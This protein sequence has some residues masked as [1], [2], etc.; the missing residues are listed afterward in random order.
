MWTGNSQFS[1]KWPKC[2]QEY[3]GFI[4]DTIMVILHFA[5]CNIGFIVQ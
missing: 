4:G 2:I 5:E 1:R 3:K